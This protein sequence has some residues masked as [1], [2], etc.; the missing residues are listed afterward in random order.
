[1][2]VSEPSVAET[3]LNP[4]FVGICKDTYRVTGSQESL[5]AGLNPCFVGICKDTQLRKIKKHEIVMS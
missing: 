1:M 3:S 2:I 4:C 5:D